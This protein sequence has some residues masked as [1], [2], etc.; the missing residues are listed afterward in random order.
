MNIKHNTITCPIVGILCML[1]L[2]ITV[3]GDQ[4]YLKIV[5]ELRSPQSH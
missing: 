2:R 1:K 4:D 5:G 3:K